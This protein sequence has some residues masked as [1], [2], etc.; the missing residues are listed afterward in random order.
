MND[1]SIHAHA[2]EL[3][4][5]LMAYIEA[6]Y[7]I[8]DDDLLH[9]RAELLSELGVVHQIP[10]LESTPRYEARDKFSSIK[11][12][13]PAALEALLT[14]VPKNH[15]GKQV[16]FDPPYLHQA[17]ALRQ[18]I[19][20]KQNLVI[21]T[22]TGSGKTESFLMPILA[23]LAIEAKDSQSTWQSNAV[24]AMVL[25]PMNALVNDQLSRLRAIFGDPR[26]CAIFKA[27]ANRPP[28]F[29]RYT[30]RAPYAGLR[31]TQKDGKNL[32]QIRDFYVKTWEA[33][34][35]GDESA[36]L[37]LADL[38]ARGKWPAKPDLEAWFGKPVARW[39][40]KNGQFKRAVT[41]PDDS[42]LLTRH[43]VQANPP[44]IL[45]TNY[46][47]L[48]YMLMRPIER[49]VFD[50]TVAWLKASKDHRFTLVLDEAH[51]Y[52]GAPGTEVAFLV[53]RLRDRLQIENDQFQV[54]GSTASFSA[55]TAAQ[56]F[57]ADLT[58]TS[59]S[60]MA[61]VEGKYAFRSPDG[62]GNI[63]DAEVLSA[64]D[65][66][67]F[68]QG[69]T[70]E[71]LKAV[72]DFL[73]YRGVNGV[74][75]LH[76]LLHKALFEYPPLNRLINET[77]RAALA[78]DTLPTLVFPE[79]P[80]EVAGRALLALTALA[81]S[82]RPDEDGASL[83]P[84]RVHTFFRGLPG[85]WVCMDPKCTGLPNPGT[86]VAGRL[87]SQ[88]RE[89][90]E[91]CNA[92]VLQLY[93]CR[94]CG[95][96]YGVG[97]SPTPSSPTVIWQD[98][99]ARLTFESEV[100]EPLRQVDLL[101]SEPTDG[102]GEAVF[103]LMTGEIDA[104][105]P[106]Q[107]TR[108]VYLAPIAA[109]KSQ[110]GGKTESSAAPGR[111]V[112]CGCC[113]RRS[114]RVVSPVQ[115]HETK[116]DEPLRLLVSKQLQLQPP[117]REAATALAPHRGRKVLI[118]SDSRQVA[119]RLAPQLQTYS[120][121]D[122]IRAAVAI[123]WKRLDES[124]TTPYHLGHLYTAAL[125]GAHILGIRLRPEL[126]TNESFQVY[127]QIGTMV[128][129]GEHLTGEGLAK[130][131]AVGTEA[132]ANRALLVDV[133]D[134]V[135]DPLVGFQTL[136]LASIVERADRTQFIVGLANLPDVAETPEQKLQLFRAW[137]NDW[138]DAGFYTNNMPGEWTQL[139]EDV[140][141]KVKLRGEAFDEFVK[142]LPDAVRRRF[143][144]D[145]LKPLLQCFAEPMGAGKYRLKGS[146]LALDFEGPWVTCL[147]CRTPQRPCHAIHTCAECGKPSLAA[148]DPDTNPYFRSRKGFYRDPIV[149]ALQGEGY[150]PIALIAAEHTAQLNA[151]QHEDVFS[152]GERN[153][154]LFQDVPLSG[155][156]GA[157][158][159]AID[160]LSSTTTMEVGID[161]GQL[162]GV[163]LRNMPPS[164]ASYQQRAGRAGRR[165]NAVA[166]VLA[167]SGLDTHDEHFFTNPAEMIRGPVVDPRLSLD[168]QQIA[169]R[170]LNA[171][172]LQSYLQSKTSLIPTDKDAQL[173]STLGSV[174]EFKLPTSKLNREELGAFLIAEVDTLRRRAEEILPEKIAGAKRTELLDKM[175]GKLLTALDDAIS[176]AEFTSASTT[177][178]TAED[179]TI[180]VE[181]ETGEERPVRS[182]AGSKFLL[183]RLLYK[184]ILPR[185]AFPTDVATFHVFNP[186]ES[187]KFR[188]RFE[189]LPSQGMV[190][191]L[192][193]Y[194]PG[195]DIW[196]DN[197][198]YR[199]GAIYAPVRSDLI[200]AWEERML[201]AEC[202]RCGYSDRWQPGG[203]VDLHA[204]LN[205]PA[206][207]G[208]QS[209]GPVHHWFRPTGF[210]HPHIEAPKLRPDELAPPTYATRAKLTLKT[211]DTTSWPPAIPNNPRIRVLP[212]RERL[213]VSNTGTAR[214]GFDYC[215]MCGLVEAHGS[216]N[217]K[218]RG[219]HVKPYPDE[220]ESNCPG[221]RIATH[222]I[223]GTDFVSDVALF[224]FRLEQG[225]RLPPAATITSIAMRTLAEAIARAATESVLQIEHG[226]VVAEYRPA[227]TDAGVRG[228]ESELFLYD[229]LPGGAGY[230]RRAVEDV[231]RLFVEARR[232]MNNCKGNCDSSCYR[233]LRTF[234]NRQDHGLIDRHVGAALID[235]LLNGE[236]PDFPLKRLRSARDLLIEDLC[237]HVEGTQYTSAQNSSDTIVAT[238]KG[239]VREIVI[240]HPLETP[241]GYEIFSGCDTA[242]LAISE[243]MVRRNLARATQV[244]RSWVA[245]D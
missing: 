9:Q 21:M 166:S 238:H 4:K 62:P 75:E 198:L 126:A 53:R 241:D 155:P 78:T 244:A 233:C 208:A 149:R 114:R 56:H 120:T 73:H 153:E 105:N 33:A 25:Y 147:I 69:G 225:V 90:C 228:E 72:E 173:F 122:A 162:S 186:R 23:K 132:E 161:I 140:E 39:K 169:E 106:T 84:A 108:P 156:T 48:E 167:Y 197:R 36:Q 242:R 68:N 76:Y 193:Q 138:R 240:S 191:A 196:V 42:E 6:T 27:W 181:E 234:R 32:K 59:P 91:S 43:E 192:S 107:R 94:Y 8:S 60:D 230:S 58:G 164:R 45:V 131:L 215:T 98:P 139:G 213:L 227:V 189:Y 125:L 57:V 61:V 87:Y 202:S 118:F 171:F 71:R 116:G 152:K 209:L 93:T 195:K 170:H 145:W 130:I 100:F 146:Q 10:F 109:Q 63:R 95:I 123:G 54:I 236:L 142:R 47:M 231:Q 219:T 88:P 148:F 127:E 143:K 133:I 216:P 205:C 16:L 31:T 44:D 124:A 5:A 28:R 204:V 220:R 121:R 41:L 136:A 226:E 187:T 180:E 117:S 97:F 212:T 129:A 128:A 144:S 137:L 188:P 99:G 70:A 34:E 24:R 111:F 165:A 112:K 245:G 176:D 38:R 190:A 134:A 217:S 172:L 229:T 22:G 2:L 35:R 29:A 168:N 200:K 40:D 224:S 89:R 157:L 104:K 37:L 82:A 119:A 92:V 17:E 80:D 19:V 183:D 182:P 1:A 239:L 101:L 184:G 206:C 135:R 159:P 51:L 102:S 49:S 103:D 210:A 85:L 178:N 207:Q 221:N 30:S 232:L 64:I 150:T 86:G 7:H 12:L 163:A 154:L 151:A 15:L 3:H 218:L 158:L 67:I 174:A 243:L 46:S 50:H 81:S 214:A 96:A 52:R 175:A 211:A 185:Y 194:A 222:V 79:V 141:V 13:H 237:R 179:E 20:R 223:L 115:D 177:W 65:L 201:H 160:V 74:G 203:S 66:E 18:T 113:G 235:F 110:G 77:M 199:S 55:S 14:L 11:D 26:I 83:L